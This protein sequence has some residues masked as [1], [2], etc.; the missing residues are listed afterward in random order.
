MGGKKSLSMFYS[1]QKKLVFTLISTMT[2]VQKATPLLPSPDILW[3]KVFAQYNQNVYLQK[4]SA[5]AQTSCKYPLS[6][7]TIF[8][9]VHHYKLLFSS[10]YQLCSRQHFALTAEHWIMGKNREKTL[11]VKSIFV[12]KDT[13][14]T[15]SKE[16]SNKVFYNPL[17]KSKVTSCKTVLYCSVFHFPFLVIPL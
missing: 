4:S 13:R 16:Y 12:E 9:A 17:W 5:L 11:S 2:Y 6:L 10:Y 1:A 14:T 8:N 3:N 15:W 7:V